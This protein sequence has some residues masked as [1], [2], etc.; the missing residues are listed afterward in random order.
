MMLSSPLWQLTGRLSPMTR[1]ARWRR[2]GW[3]GGHVSDAL[4]QVVGASMVWLLALMASHG[5]VVCVVSHKVALVEPLVCRGTWRQWCSALPH[6][7]AASALQRRGYPVSSHFHHVPKSSQFACWAVDSY[8]L[9][10]QRVAGPVES[11]VGSGSLA[12]FAPWCLWSS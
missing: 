7:L 8:A 1:C 2:G 5:V 6:R 11:L 9:P 4:H 3:S 12:R 10:W